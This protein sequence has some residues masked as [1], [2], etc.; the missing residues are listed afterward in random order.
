MG[1]RSFIAPLALSS[2]CTTLD[3][4]VDTITEVDRDILDGPDKSLQHIGARYPAPGQR[5]QPGQQYVT[6]SSNFALNVPGRLRLATPAATRTCRSSPRVSSSSD[7]S[8]TNI[9]DEPQSI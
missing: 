4:A 2:R 3:H 1:V 6:A 8:V 9:G 5:P 7:A